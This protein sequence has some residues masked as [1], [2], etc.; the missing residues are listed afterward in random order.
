MFRPI[1]TPSQTAV[2]L[3]DGSDSRIGATIGTTTTAISMKSRKKPR[4]KI[5]PITMTNFI[6]N[7]P[8]REFRKSLTRSSPPKARKADVSIAAPRRMMKT[9]DVAFA[10]SSITP[11]RV[12]SICST[13]M[14]DQINAVSNRIVAMTPSVMPVTSSG[15]SIDLTF[16]S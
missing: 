10:V 9:S 14:P 13:R 16:M 1:M 12:S 6:Q 3:A 4:K 2:M 5:T 11:R 15:L 7:P 8:G